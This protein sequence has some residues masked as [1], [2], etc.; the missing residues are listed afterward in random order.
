MRQSFDARSHALATSLTWL[1]VPWRL[2]LTG[3]YGHSRTRFK[4][5]TYFNDQF[6]S[7]AGGRYDNR[8]MSGELATDGPLFALPGG[9]AKLAVGAGLRNNNFGLFR[10]AGAVQNI[11][12]SQ[13][14]LYAYGELSLPLTSP[15]LGLPLIRRLDLSGAL[16][17]ERYRRIAAVVTP[18]LGV[19]Y[20][21]TDSIDLKGTWGRSF[22]APSF[23]QQ[24]QVQQV[25]LYPAA[26]FGGTSYPA[27]STALLRVGGNPDLKPEKAQSWSATLTFRPPSLPGADIELSYFSTRY[28]DRIVNP[29][30]LL[31]QALS[32][33][34]YRDRIT[35]SP[36]AELQAAIVAQANQ[37]INVTGKAYDPTAVAALV[38][39]ANVNAGRQSIHG[40]DALVRYRTDLARG[41]LE[42]SANGSYLKSEQQ[43]SAGLPVQ[44]LAGQLFNPP[45]W[46]A[47]GMLIW[48]RGPLTMV[49]IVSYSGGVV[50]GRAT[51]SLRIAGMT[52]ADVTL[53]YR[54]SEP[55]G[56][57]AGTARSLS[58]Q[59][60]FNATP[61]TIA[62]SVFYDTPYDST[63]Y[64]PVGRFV[65]VELS[66]RW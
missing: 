57:L 46:R 52:T 28:V 30:P 35:I 1:P 53:R 38:D 66:K 48:A 7:S 6:A 34:L 33:P 25:L 27:G 32:N 4:G 61:A 15:E 13:D 65:A 20:S 45:H 21:P 19:I 31:A 58:V 26:T 23:I 10:G 29:I 12:A 18:K 54:F 44:P 49:S 47:R 22:R 63:N 56:P 43:L 17:Y 40:V 9:S 36:T 5:D 11:D 8:S 50:D 64:S 62:T 3:T 42:I 24:Y 51:P 2:S 16:R 60:L 59:N 14:I 55:K 39:G 41:R 37:F